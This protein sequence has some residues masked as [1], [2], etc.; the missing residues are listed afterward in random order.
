VDDVEH[1]GG[2]SEDDELRMA[3]ADEAT[4]LPGAPRKQFTSKKDP[5]GALLLSQSARVSADVAAVEALRLTTSELFSLREARKLGQA[6]ALTEEL[7]K[8]L[9]KAHDIPESSISVFIGPFNSTYAAATLQRNFVETVAQ[10]GIG[11]NVNTYV[12]LPDGDELQHF[13]C[14]LHDSFEEKRNDGKRFFLGLEEVKDKQNSYRAPIVCANVL[15]RVA[16]NATMS[17][18]NSDAETTMRYEMELAEVMEPGS[19]LH[20][21]DPFIQAMRL[22]NP[23]KGQSAARSAV[24]HGEDFKARTLRRIPDVLPW[25]G[26]R[27]PPGE[28][29]KTLQEQ[30]P[31][32]QRVRPEM[33]SSKN[34]NQIL[35]PAYYRF[36]VPDEANG[37]RWA[38]RRVIG[39]K[40]EKI[41]ISGAEKTTSS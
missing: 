34:N 35:F 24:L 7:A 33:M 23:R 31:Q 38:R 22:D 11:E 27:R 41:Y 9:E 36:R 20:S 39:G 18:M 6:N 32:C 8:Y 17:R 29:F 37:G 3:R 14:S 21:P 12:M 30:F 13:P 25:A 4:P 16:N 1:S 2:V 10:K 15:D 28:P 26:R 40:D 19:I 5:T